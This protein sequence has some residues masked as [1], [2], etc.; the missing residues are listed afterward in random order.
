VSD[1]R[2]A[3][4]VERMQHYGLKWSIPTSPQ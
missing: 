1:A 3:G 2:P 4:R